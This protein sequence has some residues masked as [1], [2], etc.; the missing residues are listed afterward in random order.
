MVEVVIGRGETWTSLELVG[1]GLI[2]ET[3]VH[4]GHTGS[5]WVGVRVGVSGERAV[6][7]PRGL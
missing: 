4:T 2:D 7:H 1:G 5:A 3:G 6:G